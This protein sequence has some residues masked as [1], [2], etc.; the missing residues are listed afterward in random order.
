[1]LYTF[2][3]L[4]QRCKFYFIANLVHKLN[5]DALTIEVTVKIE[6]MDFQDRLHQVSHRRPYAH[7]G[8]TLIMR[9]IN[10]H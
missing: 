6:Q 9:A 3:Q 1:M 10:I 8:R 7:V 4:I 5:F 2:Y